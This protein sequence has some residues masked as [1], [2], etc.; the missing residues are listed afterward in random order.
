M[1]KRKM[2]VFLLRVW[3]WHLFIYIY[4]YIYPLLLY[5]AYLTF[6]K[7][8]ILRICRISPVTCCIYK[9]DPVLLSSLWDEVFMM[10]DFFVTAGLLF[11]C[12]LRV[13]CAVIGVK[14]SFSFLFSV[15]RRGFIWILFLSLYKIIYLLAHHSRC[16]ATSASQVFHSHLN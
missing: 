7:N 14:N 6:K 16:C 12:Q 9:A 15:C 8:N 10:L 2:S 5:F 11:L 4:I 1:K 13:S 3:C